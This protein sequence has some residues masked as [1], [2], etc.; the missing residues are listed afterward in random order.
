MRIIMLRMR[1]YENQ[2][3]CEIWVLH[4]QFPKWGES[5]LISNSNLMLKTSSPKTLFIK[6]L[7]TQD[8]YDDEAV[9]CDLGCVLI[10]PKLKE[11][12]VVKIKSI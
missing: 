6:W 10:K 1:F 4:P 8:V 12:M 7:T 9:S 11:I 5:F 3:A 2:Y